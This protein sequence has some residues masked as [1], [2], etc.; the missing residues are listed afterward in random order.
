[1]P[2]NNRLG[3]FLPGQKRPTPRSG[4]AQG[5]RHL[6]PEYLDLARYEMLRSAP[7]SRQTFRD[8]IPSSGDNLGGS[9][10]RLGKLCLGGVVMSDRMKLTL[11]SLVVMMLPHG[12]G[13]SLTLLALTAT[14]STAIDLTKEVLGRDV[15]C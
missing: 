7:G 2:E 9:D 3:E 4:Y 1:M 13:Y 12:L 6:R 15:A 10:I 11:A 8:V 14:I 5:K